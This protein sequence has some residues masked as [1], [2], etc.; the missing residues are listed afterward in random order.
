VVAVVYAM[1]AA[2]FGVLAQ[3]LLSYDEL[4]TALEQVATI[5]RVEP[6]VGLEIPLLSTKVKIWACVMAAFVALCGFGGGML[7]L[8]RFRHLERMLKE[9][10]AELEG[11]DNSRRLFFAKASHELRTPVTAMRG[12]AE[13]ALADAEDT[14]ALRAALKHVVAHADFLGH[15]IEEMIGLA[16]TAD[17]KL[18]LDRQKLDLRQ[19]VS[20]A[21][22]S[23]RAFAS[24][25][26]VEINL[27]LPSRP[28]AVLGDELWLNRSVLAVIE[29]ALKFSPMGGKVSVELEAKETLAEVTVSDEG[30]GIVAEEL[31][32]VFEAYYQA[33]A[34]RMRGGSG[35]GL[36]MTRWVAEQHGGKATARNIGSY[37]RP[38]GCAVTISVASV[39]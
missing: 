34:G 20:N 11:V 28:M 29:N 38:A 35:L 18:H 1:S 26:E 16:R 12:E 31:P 3:F 14:G 21:V 36:A 32:L 33:D 2:A 4:S 39:A 30:P 7:F 19:V 25:V 17:G 5:S 23:S 10:A 6:S 8:S 13:V 27:S 37:V 22:Q 24:S 9:R 15:R